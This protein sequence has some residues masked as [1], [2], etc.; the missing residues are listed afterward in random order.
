MMDMIGSLENTMG[1]SPTLY[2]QFPF[3]QTLI[4]NKH[5][6]EIKQFLL[7][8][9]PPTPCDCNLFDKK[10][11]CNSLDIPLSKILS[12]AKTRQ[13]IASNSFAKKIHYNKY[14]FHLMLMEMII[15]TIEENLEVFQR[16]IMAIIERFRLFEIPK[17]LRNCCQTEKLLVV[18]YQK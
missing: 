9:Q 15:K 11:S 10:W 6:V 14:S 18:A 12:P 2:N 17:R 13:G 5:L 3:Q 4:S 1:F 16:V 8:S 7:F